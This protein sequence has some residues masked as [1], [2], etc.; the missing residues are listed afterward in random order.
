MCLGDEFGN[1]TL[2]LYS[3][4][5]LLTI[6]NAL[7]PPMHLH[8][9]RAEWYVHVCTTLNYICKLTPSPPPPTQGLK[10]TLASLDNEAPRGEGSI[11]NRGA[12][13]KA[14]SVEKLMRRNKV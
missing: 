14:V 11:S 3:L 12:L 2:C 6:T 8:F 10:A 9:L 13:A 1:G 4:V 7:H 5:G